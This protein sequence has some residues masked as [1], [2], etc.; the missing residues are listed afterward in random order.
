MY[1]SSHFQ[2]KNFSPKI[3]ILFLGRFI[4]LPHLLITLITFFLYL[5][6]GLCLHFDPFQMQHVLC[7]SNFGFPH[8]SIP[9]PWQYFLL[10]LPFGHTAPGHP[11]GKLP[12]FCW[13]LLFSL[14]VI[15]LDN[16]VQ[17]FRGFLLTKPGRGRLKKIFNSS[18]ENLKLKKKFEVFY[19]AKHPLIPSVSL[20]CHSRTV[21]TNRALQSIWV[22]KPLIPC[23]IIFCLFCH[24]FRQFCT[25]WNKK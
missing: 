24:R 19:H 7:Q 17:L 22:K 4:L 15:E 14:F 5:Y 18:E 20:F 16:S 8:L 10:G 3:L 25:I 13:S 9:L 1:K 12:Y 2:D 11:F 23:N 6:F 21:D